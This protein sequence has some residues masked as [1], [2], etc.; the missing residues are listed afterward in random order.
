[1]KG[2]KSN[3]SKKV[4]LLMVLVL[5]MGLHCSKKKVT[6]EASGRSDGDFRTITFDFDK[7]DIRGDARDILAH[8]AD[9]LKKNPK[10]EVQVD[11]HCDERGSTEYNLALGQ[12]RANATKAYLVNLGV[13]SS[14][15]ST[16]SYGEERPVD[17]GHDESAW[18]KNRRAEF[19]ITSK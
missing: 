1:M 7:Y 13:E 10:M 4:F 6:E 18:D 19:R 14:R 15:V 2:G 12:R 3:M 16:I 8:N 11:G 17:A 5:V 9:Y